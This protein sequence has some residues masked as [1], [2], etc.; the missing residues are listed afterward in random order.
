MVN[1]SLNKI[2]ISPIGITKCVTKLKR[3]VTSNIKRKIS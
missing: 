2:I 1:R 3:I